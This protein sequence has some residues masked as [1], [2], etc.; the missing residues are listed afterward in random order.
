MQLSNEHWIVLNIKRS[1]VHHS[2]RCCVHSRIKEDLEG[3]LHSFNRFKILHSNKLYQ[4]IWKFRGNSERYLITL[5]L[6]KHFIDLKNLPILSSY[7]FHTF[8]KKLLI[9]DEN[10]KVLNILRDKDVKRFKW[11]IYLHCILKSSCRSEA[12]GLRKY[13]GERHGS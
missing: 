2:Q 1:T 5:N 13:S 10:F 11:V 9:S 4:M 3:Y 8:L 6:I 12:F 7:C